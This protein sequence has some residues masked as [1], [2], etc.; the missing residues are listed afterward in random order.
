MNTLQID[1]PQN[2]TDIR[3]WYVHDDK[4]IKPL[5]IAISRWYRD[6]VTGRQRRQ[7][8]PTKYLRALVKSDE[9]AKNLVL[10]LN[11]KDPKE[12]AARLRYQERVAWISPELMRSYESKVRNNY[13]SEKDFATVMNYL[14]KY[15]LDFFVNRLK[16]PDVRMWKVSQDLWG[17][18]LLNKDV[19]EDDPLRIMEPGK[20]FSKKVLKYII[21][22]A[23]RFLRFVH[24]QMPLE[25]PFIK[26]E[27]LDK[28]ALINADAKRIQANGRKHP[29]VY[30]PPI[31]LTKILTTLKEIVDKQPWA[32][33]A[34]LAYYYGVRTGETVALDTQNIKSGYLLVETQFVSW[35]FDEESEDELEPDAVKHTRSVKD[36]EQRKVP[37]WVIKPKEAYELVTAINKAKFTAEW[38]SDQFTE[39]TRE[40]FKSDGLVYHLKDLRKTWV[41]NMLKKHNHEQVRLAAGHS[42]IKTTLGH[43]VEDGREMDDEV[44]MPGQDEGEG[45]D[46]GPDIDRTG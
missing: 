27:P 40:L 1:L 43:Y 21:N 36:R 32:T 16:E 26:L 37:H 45:G 7:R 33:A 22:E 18:Y 42:D 41:T 8:L 31:R 35:E 17:T 30:I 9:D 15:V 38:A 34:L 44:Y 13:T 12:E 25:V 6:V 3:P 28:M 20:L 23:N 5:G 24:N 2:A 29:G 10:R 11:G 19:A 46:G 14:H 4:T 39:L